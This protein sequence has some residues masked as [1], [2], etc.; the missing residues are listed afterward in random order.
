MHPFDLKKL[1]G[2]KSCPDESVLKEIMTNIN[3]TKK[4]SRKCR[5]NRFH[6]LLNASAPVI[7]FKNCQ[8]SHILFH[9]VRL[10]RLPL[11][12]LDLLL[13][14]FPALL[15]KFLIA[16]FGRCKIEFEQKKIQ[17]LEAPFTLT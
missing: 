4:C 6:H 12:P 8:P 2:G 14:L 5:F 7:H 1:I 15:I 13:F 10:R 17:I 9:C 3:I 11:H 16:E